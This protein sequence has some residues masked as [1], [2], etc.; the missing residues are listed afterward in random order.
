M[1]IDFFY[2][3]IGALIL[4][5][6]AN[7][8][9]LG[10]KSIAYRYKLSPII[11]GITLVAFGTSLPELIVS[12]FAVVKDDSGIVIGNVFGSNIA[13]IGLVLGTTAIIS[14]IYFHYEKIR[15]DL[16]TLLF[17]TLI[18]TIFIYLNGMNMYH[19]IF[20][21]FLLIVYCVS[22]F[23]KNVIDDDIVNETDSTIFSIFAKVGFGILGLSIGANFIVDSAQN[24]A[25][26]L[27]LPSVLI[28][29]SIVALGTSLPELAASLASIKHKQEG[30]VIGN[31]IGSN[32]FN[33]LLVLGLSIIVKP[34]PIN[35]YNILLQLL[36]MV[37]LTIL[38]YI[39][40]RNKH[41]ISRLDGLW[42]LI[43]YILFLYFNFS[44]GLDII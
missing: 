7:L 17:S 33:I 27:G 37:I 41:G 24:I 8:L 38:L 39:L 15:F 2:F 12:L 19:G 3:V 13:N 4:Y 25:L 28:G 30:F 29:M 44:K 16:F 5:Y 35:F 26:N 40:L 34:I 20:Y 23:Y 11:I 14:P 42:I 36:F 9:I 18:T 10:S 31:I 22:L 43:I 6:G 1:I 21:I 32:L